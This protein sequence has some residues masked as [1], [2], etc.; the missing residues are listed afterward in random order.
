MRKSAATRFKEFAVMALLA[1][2][3]LSLMVWGANLSR[4]TG[5]FVFFPGGLLALAGA[6]LVL[7]AFYYHYRKDFKHTKGS[8]A[9][10][11]Y[12][13]LAALNGFVAMLL[14]RFLFRR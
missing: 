2:S 6:V 7:A 10:A 14:V 3:G 5:Q 11:G 8:K 4:A 1:L 9:F 13:A 12:M